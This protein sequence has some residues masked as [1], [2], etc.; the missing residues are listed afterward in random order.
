MVTSK[1]RMLAVEGFAHL[2]VRVLAGSLRLLLLGIEPLL[3]FH[4]YLAGSDFSRH[5]GSL[6]DRFACGKAHG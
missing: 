3:L 5:G 2:F 4:N 1:E 6:N